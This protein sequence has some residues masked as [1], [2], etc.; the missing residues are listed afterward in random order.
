[1]K[2]HAAERGGVN[3]KSNNKNVQMEDKMT[4]K[5]NGWVV[6]SFTSCRTQSQ[7]LYAGLSC[8]EQPVMRFREHHT[9][10]LNGTKTVGEHFASTRTTTNCLKFSYN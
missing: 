2:P 3:V 1:M 4:C 8:R 10:I 6:P 9:S 7:V 5:S